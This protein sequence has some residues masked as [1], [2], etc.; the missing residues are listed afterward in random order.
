MRTP[1]A[2]N[3]IPTYRVADLIVRSIFRVLP[4]HSTLEHL[5]LWWGYHYQPPP[6]V[7]R[8]RSGG[9]IQFENVDHLQLILYYFGVFEPHC[10]KYL[11]LYARAGGTVVDVGA[12]IG[13]FTIESSLAV[14]AGG[15][16]IAIEAAPPHISALHANLRLNDIKNVEVIESGVGEENC[17]ANLTLP[18]GSNLGMFTVGKV[19]GRTSYQINLRTLDDL[20]LE[21]DVGPVDLIKMD[22]EGSEFRALKGARKTLEKYRPTLIIELNGTA[23]ESC[24]SSV[25]QVVAL[26]G[27]LNYVGRRI[28]G[29]KL[30]KQRV[31]EACDEY[32]FLPLERA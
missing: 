25:D 2:K 17:S 20:L 24:G 13:F 7:V 26:L 3:Q 6:K 5:A 19:E 29:T 8:L 28:S 22:I 11:R 27:D 32:V 30:V 15:R 16:V 4:L 21:H 12:N 1:K 14:G 9:L 10:I 18:V 31:E 23:L